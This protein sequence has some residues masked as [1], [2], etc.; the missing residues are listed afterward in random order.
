MLIKATT[1]QKITRS[2]SISP[3]GTRPW[4]YIVSGTPSWLMMNWS[5][6]LGEGPSEVSLA[7]VEG[8]M[9]WWPDSSFSFVS[10]HHHQG[11]NHGNPPLC[12][13][14][15]VC[16]ISFDSL[17]TL[18]QSLMRFVAVPMRVWICDIWHCFCDKKFG[19]H[20]MHETRYIWEQDHPWDWH[21]CSIWSFLMIYFQSRKLIF[22]QKGRYIE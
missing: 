1:T 14:C 12:K 22:R 18:P 21:K 6:G 9:I 3:P 10:W 11:S 15:K 2:I 8:L 17:I 20:G 13:V 4:C 5:I 7:M 16:Q 19:S